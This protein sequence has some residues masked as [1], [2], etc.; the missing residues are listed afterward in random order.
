MS[1]FLK[2]LIEGYVLKR[3]AELANTPAAGG[4]HYKIINT[5]AAFVKSINDNTINDPTI[6]IKMKALTNATS[7]Q[8]PQSIE[9]K[10]LPTT[11]AAGAV[12]VGILSKQYQFVDVA[13]LVE[14][15]QSIQNIQVVLTNNSVQFRDSTGFVLDE[16]YA[17][18]GKGIEHQKMV[19][20]TLGITAQC[21]EILTQCLKTNAN[22][23]QCRGELNTVQTGTL[24]FSATETNP[25][26]L[27]NG[28]KLL[29]K[30]E[31]PFDE[32]AG[33]LLKYADWIAGTTTGQA[34]KAELDRIDKDLASAT[35]AD[36]AAQA[37]PGAGT[38]GSPEAIAAA[39]AAAVLA[40]ATAEEAAKKMAVPIVR[41]Y[42][43]HIAEALNDAITKGIPAGLGDQIK[44]VYEN[45]KYKNRRHKR[46][47]L[48]QIIDLLKQG[49]FSKFKM[50]TPIGL[51]PFGYRFFGGG[52]QPTPDE[53]IKLQA[54]LSTL[55]KVANDL[56]K[57][58]HQATKDEFTKQLTSVGHD[59]D[60]L[61]GILQ[62]LSQDLVSQEYGLTDGTNQI[63]LNA[64][65]ATTTTA[66]I[67][68]FVADFKKAWESKER[69]ILR[70]VNGIGLGY[71]ILFSKLGKA[72]SI[73]SDNVRKYTGVGT[74]NATKSNIITFPIV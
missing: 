39:A 24:T 38:A 60:T 29:S 6:F 52:R 33:K 73:N 19:C 65:G 64:S 72:D 37:A 41:D 18:D 27:A 36:A 66:E 54:Q 17:L 3:N 22:N 47:N 50:A 69:H 15:F 9:L 58:L 44:K 8:A 12:S 16:L 71:T 2:S 4:K 34:Y 63:Q 32:A 53:M 23:A 31:W 56:G 49:R 25:V 68:K 61:K 11:R 46:M 43:N 14:V 51:M 13:H 40:K 62:A 7:T 20:T 57:K 42:L 55:E 26:K 48:S 28:F 74:T 21:N 30:F 67:Q 1:S 59:I 10:D 35:A 70:F 5:D 45:I